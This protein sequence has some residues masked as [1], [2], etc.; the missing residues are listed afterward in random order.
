MANARR[1]LKG[2]REAGEAMQNIGA[3]LT[4]AVSAPLALMATGAIVASAEMETLKSGLQAVAQQELGKSGITGLTGMQQAAQQTGERIKELTALAKAPGLGLAQAE[5][6]DIR[7]RAVGTTVQESTREIKEFANAIATTGG[8][9]TQF[10]LVTT[11]LSQMAAKGKV[12]AEDLKPIIS[13]A[14][15]VAGALQRLYGTVDSETISASLKKQ[16]QSSKDFIATL[17]TELA[18]LPRVTGGLKAIYENDMDA[19]LVASAKVGDGIAKSLNLQAVGE[20]LGNTITAIGDNFANLSAPAQT[21]IVAIAGVAAATGP[22]LVGLGTLGVALP[23]VRAG[24]VA[25]KSGADLLGGG[26]AALV[27][28]TGLVIAGIAAL[29]AGAYYLATANERALKTYQDQARETDNL[30]ATITPL[31]ARYEQLNGTTNRTQAE[32]AELNDVIKQLAATVPG[33]TAAIDQYGNVTAISATAVNE[34]TKAL[35]QKKGA[36]AALNLPAASQKLEELATR[37]RLLK[38]RADEFNR[39]GGIQ[40][41]GPSLGPGGG[42]V[43]TTYKAGSQAVLELQANLAS[44]N[45][46]FLQQKQVVEGLRASVKSLTTEYQGGL[47]PA[48]TD[49]ELALKFLGGQGSETKGLLAGLHEELKGLKQEQ[50]DAPTAQLALAYVP[51]IKNLQEYIAKLEGTD[52]ASHKSA[53]AIAKLRLE[54]SRLTALDNFLGDAPN[55]LQVLERRSAAL[56]PGLKS[57]IDAGVS[58]ASKAFKTFAQ[59]LVT[60]SQAADR[61]MAGISKSKPDGEQLELKTVQVKSLIPQ[62][63][64]DTL[65]ADVARLLGD[66][67]KRAIPFE[68]PL[69]AKLNMQ[70]ISEAMQPVQLLNKEL[71]KLAGISVK[72]D[73]DGF[74]PKTLKAELDSLGKSFQEIAASAQVFGGNFDAAGARAAKLQES[75]QNLIAKGHRPESEEV[76]NLTK[77]YNDNSRESALNQAQAAAMQAALSSLSAAAEGVGYALATGG[78]TTEA[79]LSGLLDTVYSFMSEYGKQ[80][81][82][83]GAADIAIGNVGKGFAEVAAGVALSLGA[84][85]AKGASSASKSTS[86][87]GSS[88]PTISNY[89][90]NSNTQTVRV[91]AEFQLRG[92][93]LVAIG[94]SQ[95]Y[96]SSVSD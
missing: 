1:E 55:Q 47:T 23:A 90:Q 41:A 28:P 15:A 83:I 35:Q 73:W 74:V 3:S 60:T 38:Q 80:L 96:R 26:L 4:K 22:V 34:F 91:I 56:I 36:L 79:L 16:G 81:V 21:A 33:A 61:I 9:A 6:A 95:E 12:L 58:P 78:D 37:Y 48:L 25:A 18:K 59:D 71:L 76:Q 62:N 75:I 84:G 68:L 65:D 31:L 57:L 8:G 45:V 27:S 17:T 53:D 93:D 85:V 51:L 20:E 5:Q 44:A 70:N 63:I 46:E 72:P 42:S 66:Y 14:P 94:R 30:T 67:A 43:V 52:K 86:T 89:G 24:L 7:L 49:T 92:E 29:A 10:E 69:A 54:L 19:L 77:Q 32:Q 88:S 40:V 13:A 64:G 82:L 87:A 50:Q 11:Q 2:L 39:T